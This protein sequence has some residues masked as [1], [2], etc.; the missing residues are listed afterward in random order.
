MYATEEKTAEGFKTV[1][2]RIDEIETETKDTQLAVKE[3]NE[4]IKAIRQ[5]QKLYLRAGMNRQGDEKSPLVFPDLEL[6]KTFGEMVIN[7]PRVSVSRGK[8]MSEVSD[9]Q[10]V[11]SEIS[12][13]LLNK[14]SEYG[15]FRGNAMVVPMGAASTQLPYV[16]GDLTVYSPG[17]GGEID[18]SDLGGG[19]VNLVPHKLACLARYSAELEDDSIA[20]LG[21]LVGQS[22][23]RSLA[24]AEDLAGFLGDG[25]STYWS[26]RGITGALLAVDPVIANIKSLVVG[27]GNA[28]SELVLGD[29]RKV[30]GRLPSSADAGA[31]WYMSKTFFFEVVLPLLWAESA[32]QPVL[33]T[34]TYF[35]QGPTKFLLGY[36]VEFTQ[37]MPKKE[38][39]SQIVAILA[40]LRQGVILGE[41]KSLSIAR[42][43]HVHFATDEI[44]IRGLERIAIAPYSVGDTA[45]A[46]NIV[47]LITAAS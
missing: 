13:L 37:V 29:F 33:G 24:K 18:E 41:R 47:G 6:A 8:A 44:A 5:Q 2:E 23:A 40:D 26:F 19:Q 32:G 46:G 7:A 14:I 42:S 15:V 16:T 39:N 38:A 35:E 17:E 1:G 36:P 12:T 25:S 30:C 27:S 21:E 28:Y 34:P 45:D 20:A 10:L 22:I 9:G 3:L 11:G 31:R 4:T 43:E